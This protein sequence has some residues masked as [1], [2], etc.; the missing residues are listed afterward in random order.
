MAALGDGAGPQ[1]VD[2][3]SL[4]VTK[5]CASEFVCY[6]NGTLSHLLIGPF[7]PNTLSRS[8]GTIS[9]CLFMHEQWPLDHALA[10]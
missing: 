2:A 3:E 6:L 8:S 7:H 10:L 9:T 5:H 1:P 4:S